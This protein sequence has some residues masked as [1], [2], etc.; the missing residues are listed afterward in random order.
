MTSGNQG[1]NSYSMIYN[2]TI[3]LTVF[4]LLGTQHNTRHVRFQSFMISRCLYMS[5]T[6]MRHTTEKSMS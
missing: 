6:A 5:K 1:L 4:Y 2:T 3:Q